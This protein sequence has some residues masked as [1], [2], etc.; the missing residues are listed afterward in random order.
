MRIDIWADLICPW[1]YI[2]MARFD[3]AVSA[4]PHHDEI[5]V[6]HRSFELDPT[7]TGTEPVLDMLTKKYGPG[8]A[9]MESRVA[10]LAAEEGL[11]YR[12]DRDVGNTFDAH[13]LSHLAK[14]KGL[15]EAFIDQALK[16]NFAE[17]RSLFTHDSLKE[18]AT[19][20]GL[21]PTD[22]QQVL[23]DPT[24]YAE[25][26]RTDEQEAT[27]IGATGVP[28]FVLDDRYAIS[29]AQPTT[30]FTDALTQAWKR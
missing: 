1:C 27:A 5:T 16:A 4:S 11:P 6:V 2:G 29:G 24:A 9:D 8:A 23:A 13:R 18:I 30:L 21:D 19:E 26:V 17:A 15:Q 12:T 22:T 3:K 7:T 20:A 10:T 14:S 25:A 28:F